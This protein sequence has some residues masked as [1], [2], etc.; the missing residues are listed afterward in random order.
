MSS[1]RILYRGIERVLKGKEPVEEEKKKIA[2]LFIQSLVTIPEGMGRDLFSYYLART[3]KS[4]EN[5]RNLA[6]HLVEVV[7][8]FNGEY[9]DKNNPLDEGEWLIIRDLMNAYAAEIEEDILTYVMA[10]I[11]EKGF[12]HKG[13]S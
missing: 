7:D 1:S 6:Y 3:G 2:N 8:L 12:F 9:D 10:L 11:V 5:L 13:T 4:E